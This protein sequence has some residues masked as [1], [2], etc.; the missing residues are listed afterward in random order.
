VFT[1]C[2]SISSNETRRVDEEA[3]REGWARLTA[4]DRVTWILGE[5][6]TALPQE[7]RKEP[8][9]KS[10]FGDPEAIRERIQSIPD[11]LPVLPLRDAVIFPTAVMPL[12]VGRESSVQLINDVQEGD[13]LLAVL[14]QREKTVELPGPEDLYDDGTVSAVH[15]VMRTPEGNLFVIVMALARMRVVEFTQSEPYLRARIEVIQEDLEEENAVDFQALRRSVLGQF[16]RVIRLSPQLPD[17]LQTFVINIE[18]SGRLADY[19]ATNLPNLNVVSKQLV[20]SMSSARER[21]D[22]LNT[23][24]AKEL[25]VLEL[26]TKLQSQVEEEVG[27]TQREYFL[28]EQLR[29]IQKELGEADDSQREIDE[30]REQIANANLPEEAAKEAERELTRLQRMPPAAADYTVT[31]TYLDWLVSLPWNV[32]TRQQVDIVRAKEI[33]DRDHHDLEKI[34][35]RILEYL[36]VLELRP[37]GK[38]P[39]LCLVGPPGVGKTSLGRSIAEATGRRFMRMSLGGM[40]DEAEIRGHRRTYIGALPGQIIQN[41]RRA[42]ARDPVLM[43]DEVDKLG[44]DF[45]G[46]PAAALLEVLDPEQN[47]SFRD[48]YLDVAFDLSRVFFIT[49]ANVL[50][51]I[52]SALRDRMETIELPGYTEEEKV[53]IARDYLVPRQREE[54]GLKE[55]QIQFSEDALQDIVRYYTRE[56]GV[57]NL[58]R[59]VGNVCRKYA[60]R[61]LE[62]EA[63]APDVTRD[64]VSALLG[65]PKYKVAEEL[66][67]RVK[68]PGVAVGLAWTPVGGEV[69]FVETN[70]AGGGRHLTVTG[71]LGDVM[72]ESA[73]AALTWVRSM[74]SRLG[75]E[76]DFYK[77][78]DVHIH[79]PSGAIPKDG[80]SAGVTM[81]TSLVS[82]LT[83]RPVRPKLAMTGEITLSGHVLPVG[84]IKEKV[85]A[86]RRAGV[87]EILVP[88]ENKK[89]V[90]EDIQEEL[91]ASVQ[92]RYVDTVEEVLA[93]AFEGRVLADEDRLASRNEPIER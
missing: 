67:E 32:L 75:L 56:A 91:L 18:E 54:N 4:R 36:A 58:E 63:L 64:V 13:G 93:F 48:H 50:D 43:L 12:T 74:A 83:G 11:E 3:L 88:S 53:H 46:D 34:K 14:T 35:E 9:L 62:Q 42:E 2:E 82:A 47:S 8:P 73:K 30:L 15:R 60:R 61:L 7:D 71:Q 37:E 49:T 23:E 86:A 21:L 41:I 6:T 17:D 19:I 55:D 1:K 81:V 79:V 78:R 92:I 70:M 29:A 22:F 16:E 39:I 69:L 68:R 40:R 20:L 90:L 26:R 72:Q 89:D 80:P 28:R 77:D 5:S 59:E 27:K 65:A 85:L 44:A 87:D 52:P 25:E 31:R 76:D 45:R 57:R 10:E 33:L 84:G 51:T 66:E 38:A 24:L